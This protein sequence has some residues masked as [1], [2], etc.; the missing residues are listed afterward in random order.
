VIHLARWI[1]IHCVLRPFMAAVSMLKKSGLRLMAR[2]INQYILDNEIGEKALRGRIRIAMVERR[3]LV[4]RTSTSKQGMKLSHVMPPRSS[5]RGKVCSMR[6]KA[7]E[8]LRELR[9]LSEIR[10]YTLVQTSRLGARRLGELSHHPFKPCGQSAD[11]KGRKWMLS[12]L[13]CALLGMC[14]PFAFGI[15]GCAKPPPMHAPPLPRNQAPPIRVC[16]STPE[17]LYLLGQC[18]DDPSGPS[19]QPPSP[20]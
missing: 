2:V 6:S 5:C 15:G 14:T 11:E 19:V 20:G 13:C 8:L 10:A 9:T 7:S 12:K 4:A 3:S 16:K 17:S 1:S 18:Y